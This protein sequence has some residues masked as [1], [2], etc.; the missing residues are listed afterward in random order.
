MSASAWHNLGFYLHYEIGCETPNSSVNAQR[1]SWETWQNK[2]TP[3]SIYSRSFQAW[4]FHYKDKMVVRQFC[5]YNGNPYTSK[6]TTV[7]R[8]PQ[9]SP[10]PSTHPPPPQPPPRHPT[11]TPEQQSCSWWFEFHMLVV[12][13]TLHDFAIISVRPMMVAYPCCVSDVSRVRNG[14][15]TVVGLA[16]S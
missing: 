11:T 12:N 9:L 5:L 7:L 2:N 13:T 8:P 10:P 15:N 6:M 1:V 4:D 3:V 16:E 14:T